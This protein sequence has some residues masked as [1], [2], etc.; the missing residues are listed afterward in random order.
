MN[1]QEMLDL[2]IKV[3]EHF[4]NKGVS[5]RSLKKMTK[6]KLAVDF[7]QLSDLVEIS[8][9]NYDEWA[10]HNEEQKSINYFKS[11][12]AFEMVYIQRKK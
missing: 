1:K 10:R 3:A 12:V 8:D 4:I 11:L 7:P 2:S 9:K 5:E 6:E